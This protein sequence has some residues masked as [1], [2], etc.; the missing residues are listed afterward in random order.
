MKKLNAFQVA[1]NEVVMES[2]KLNDELKSL[3]EQKLDLINQINVEI[4]NE[5]LGNASDNSDLKVSELRNKIGPIEDRISELNVKLYALEQHKPDR[6]A[7][8]RDEAHKETEE[9]VS[10]QSSQ[11]QQK[12]D[13]VK[14]LRGLYIQK[15]LE[16]EEIKTQTNNVVGEF[17]GLSRNHVDSSKENM[18]GLRLPEVDAMKGNSQGNHAP[19]LPMED[20][21]RRVFS[22]KKVPFWYEEWLLSGEIVNENEVNDRKNKREKAGAAN[23]K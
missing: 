7:K 11:L 9:F 8:S 20:E 16:A 19:I 22:E 12:L 14:S 6:L 1:I 5:A 3:Q 15:L 13:E 23:G 21:I 10:K 4:K 17:K 18:N 2:V